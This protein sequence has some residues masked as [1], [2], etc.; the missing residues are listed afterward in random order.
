MHKISIFLLT[1]ILGSCQTSVELFVSNIGIFDAGNIDR[2]IDNQS[3]TGYSSTPSGTSFYC[4]SH[5]IYISEL[6]ENQFF[7]FNYSVR[8][9]HRNHYKYLDRVGL[10]LLI[11]TPLLINSIGEVSTLQPQRLILLSDFETYNGYAFS[12]SW[13]KIPGIWSFEFY[14]KEELIGI[15][16]FDLREKIPEMMEDRIYCSQIDEA[17]IYNGGNLALESYLNEEKKNAS[18]TLPLGTTAQV[19]A[20]F[21]VNQDGSISE[22]TIIKSNS[23]FLNQEALRIVSGMKN[24]SPAQLNGLKVRSAQ[25]ISL[26]FENK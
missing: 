16:H 11:R 25:A 19:V 1:I 22:V 4:E 15:V 12:E 24:W 6:Q 5:I 2:V 23:S 14:F 13:E 20:G 17:A 10:K 18:K 8:S 21:V 26:I 3:L 7:G 9:F